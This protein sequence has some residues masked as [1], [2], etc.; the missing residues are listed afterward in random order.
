FYGF[1]TVIERQID[2][3]G[4]TLTSDPET[5]TSELAAAPVYR[6]VTRLYHNE[7]FFSK[8]L[9]A[10]ETLTDGAATPHVFTH[11]INDY[12]LLDV[13]TQKEVSLTQTVEK[14]HAI[15]DPVFP[16]LQRMTKKMS[17]GSAS[18]AIVTETDQTYDEV[19]NVKTFFDSGDSGTDD[20]LDAT[21]TYS[22]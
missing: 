13:T 3:N 5:L 19:G 15:V 1:D 21:M 12:F 9:L 8:G 22:S 11:T 16:E 20:D 6:Q 7:S 10:E 2:T 18:V 14:L 17:E 4:V